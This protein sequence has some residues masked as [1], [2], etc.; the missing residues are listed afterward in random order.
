MCYASIRNCGFIYTPVMF[1]SL[2]RL[3]A[4]RKELRSFLLFCA[5]IVLFLYILSPARNTDYSL[6]ERECTDLNSLW[7]T[8]YQHDFEFDET[9][10]FVT[11]ECGTTHAK[12]AHAIFIID[13]MTSSPKGFDFYD[14]MK[15]IN[16]R[17]S[18]RLMFGYA[19]VSYFDTHQVD[20]NINKLRTSNPVEL[21]GVLIHEIRHL[22]QGYN[23]HVPC[24]TD[25]KSRCDLRLE[26]DPL[27]GGAYNYNVVFYDQ[28]VRGDDAR[29]SMKYAASKLLRAI[30]E[31]KFNEPVAEGGFK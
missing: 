18:Q 21:A 5:F 30:L 28:L 8:K 10:R 31:T 14:W 2:G 19:G 29:R 26:D 7:Q 12:M 17:F 27:T 20:V 13:T 25:K 6:S 4:Q 11:F 15:R 16:P 24:R 1:D 22:D 9:W 23:S 3:K